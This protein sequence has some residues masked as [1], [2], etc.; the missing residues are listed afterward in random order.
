M[1][2]TFF[3]FALLCFFLI[4]C[5]PRGPLV[6]DERDQKMNLKERILIDSVWAGHPVG[7]ALLTEGNRQFIAYYNKERNM[8]VG[9][10]TLDQKTFSLFK[11]PVFNREEGHGISTILNWDS[12]NYVTIALDKEGY[13]H[14]SGNM[15][16]HP[17]TYFRSTAP[18]DISSMEQIHAMVGTEESRCTYPKFLTNREGE[19][20]FHYRD[21]SSGSGNEIYNMYSTENKSWRRLLDTPLTDGLGLMNAY[22]SQPKLYEDDWYHMYWVWRDTPDCE[23]NHDL[24]YMKSKDLKQWYSAFGDPIQ[25]P[26]TLEQKALIVDPIPPGGGIINLA[27]RLSLD[28]HL[29]TVMAY[30]KYDENGNLQL[31][32]ASAG[33]NDW[34]YTQITDWD[35]RWEFSGRGSIVFEVRLG[36]FIRRKD[37]RYELGYNHVKYGEGTLLLDKNFQRIGEVLKPEN[38]FSNL[39]PEGDF[40]GLEIRTAR[41][42]GKAPEGMKYML[43]W[44]TLP[45]NRDRPYPEPWPAPSLLYLYVLEQP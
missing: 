30:H 18:Y 38:P 7:F 27:A 40:P 19:L 12:H 42:D 26:A 1:N 23:T 8:M 2:N 24:S 44:E 22:Q 29:R 36:D 14:L 37:G 43:K 5:G 10:R 25:L 28:E 39:E 31:Y 6:I 16:V 15:H 17:L 4:S 20:L 32:V 3:Q 9:Q 34:S 11:M 21:G 45:S 13:I 35:Y 33:E 41:D